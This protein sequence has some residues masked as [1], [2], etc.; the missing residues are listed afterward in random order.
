MCPKD[1]LGRGVKIAIRLVSWLCMA[2]QRWARSPSRERRD[3]VLLGE[4][5]RAVR[6]PLVLLAAALLHER[7]ADPV[8][9]AP[10][11]PDFPGDS[12]FPAFVWAMVFGT[13]NGLPRREPAL[14]VMAPAAT[15][16]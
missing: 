4:L 14:P 3:P 12:D 8:E 6:E 7:R 5:G 16:R 13:P 11:P 2:R 10:R 15:L 1:S 9:G